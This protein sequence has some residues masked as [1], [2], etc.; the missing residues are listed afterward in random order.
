MDYGA[1]SIGKRGNMRF[2]PAPGDGGGVDPLA[3]LQSKGAPFFLH[4]FLG[5]TD[6]TFQE[7]VGP[8]LADDATEAVGLAFSTDEIGTRSLAEILA[9][10]SELKQTGTTGTFGTATAATYNTTTGS[11]VVYRVDGSNLS[12][13]WVSTGAGNRYA[14]DIETFGSPVF[15]RDSVGFA[16]LAT[17]ASSGR[18]TL[19]VSGAGTSISFTG[20]S[21]GS[22]SFTLHS[23]KVIPGYHAA[24]AA[25]TGYLSIRQ[26]DGSVRG[27]GLDDNLLSK[28]TSATSM[29]F[30][31]AMLGGVNPASFGTLVGGPVGTARGYFGRN[32][33][34]QLCAGVG[35]DSITTIVGGGDLAGVKGVAM[36]NV[37]AG[38]NVDLEW[39]PKGGSLTS[40]YS[41]AING[42]MT[43][44]TALRI[45]ATNASGMAGNFGKDNIYLAAAAQTTLTAAERRAFAKNWNG[46]IPS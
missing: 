27:D 23:F 4:D 37:A 24:Q 46:R 44:G 19:Y 40:L 29:F 41:A 6:L 25:N 26:A 16:V 22:A 11:G 32:S 9:A 15:I 20:T 39:F 35:T 3:L 45:F 28:L 30:A 42:S 36:L 12:R 7:A 8:T 14:I 21:A 31:V 43:A 2:G 5:R 34:G 38:G 17:T 33:S 18:Q 13:V 1:L 10:Q